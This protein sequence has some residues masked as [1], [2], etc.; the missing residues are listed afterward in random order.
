MSV[1]G[2][3]RSCFQ[4]DDDSLQS[5]TGSRREALRLLYRISR[6]RVLPHRVFPI[7]NLDAEPEADLEFGLPEWVFPRWWPRWVRWGRTGTG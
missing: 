4:A 3:V 6:S 5:V 1:F 7:T 2:A